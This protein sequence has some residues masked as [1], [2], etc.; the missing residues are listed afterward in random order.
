M[1][2][3]QDSDK[4]CISDSPGSRA[5]KVKVLPGH[6]SSRVDTYDNLVTR[7]VVYHESLKRKP[8]KKSKWTPIGDVMVDTGSVVLIDAKY[9]PKPSLY[10][11]LHDTT[12]DLE[13]GK[14]QKELEHGLVQAGF[15]GDGVYLV[16]ACR[17][18]EFVVAIQITFYSEQDIE[19]MRYLD[20]AQLVLDTL[21]VDMK[22]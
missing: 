18:K 7:L 19:R 9:Y 13:E 11:D 3:Q 17:R 15:G 20:K 14:T 5:L 2:W 4:I 16:E 10:D 6:W 12:L 21:D 22:L 1:S 8:T